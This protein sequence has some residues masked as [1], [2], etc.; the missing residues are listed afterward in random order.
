MAGLW[1]D[2]FL[3]TPWDFIFGIDDCIFFPPEEGT[4]PALVRQ[5][6]RRWWPIDE[7]GS[8]PSRGRRR[9][10]RPQVAL[11]FSLRTCHGFLAPDFSIGPLRDP[12]ST[13]AL[14][15]SE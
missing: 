8:K 1:T 9:G 11:G 7:S 3:H 12:V 13:Q 14:Q 5:L 10:W 6:V 4:T 2:P 15:Q